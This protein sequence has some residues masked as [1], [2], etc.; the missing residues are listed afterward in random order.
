MS[1]SLEAEVSLTDD[2]S[3]VRQHATQ[4]QVYETGADRDDD[5]GGLDA[6]A[7]SEFV[8]DRIREGESDPSLSS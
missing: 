7:G 3:R 4:I 1:K 5:A 2:E 8:D 6:V